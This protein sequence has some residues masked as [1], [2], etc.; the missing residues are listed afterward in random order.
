[1]VKV[2]ETEDE[3]DIIVGSSHFKLPAEI[4]WRKKGAVSSVKNQLDCGSC[5]AFA[6]V[7]NLSFVIR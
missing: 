4:D 3:P 5:W 2:N 1:M 7:G 6:A